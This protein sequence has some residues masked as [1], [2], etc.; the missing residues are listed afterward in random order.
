MPPPSC[1]PPP[2]GLQGDHRG[3]DRRPWPLGSGATSDVPRTELPGPSPRTDARTRRPSMSPEPR[4]AQ[5]GRR[6][7]GG[8]AAPPPRD[9]PEQPYL[10]LFSSPASQAPQDPQEGGPSAA[11]PPPP[12][13][14]PR[15]PLGLPAPRS[16]GRGARQ[17]RGPG[18]PRARG[19]PFSPEASPTQAWRA[20]SAL[21]RP[22]PLQGAPPA[23]QSPGLPVG[24]SSR[25]LDHPR[26]LATQPGR[27]LWLQ[28]GSRAGTTVS[29]C[30][31]SPGAMPGHVC[32][33]AGQ[34]WGLGWAGTAEPN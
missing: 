26:P 13:C 2:W 33:S 32:R 12:W 10:V 20:C 16:S 28:L 21:H 11:C 23:A 29:C 27:P 24:G 15:P 4:S 19:S 5:E 25:Q 31:G 6:A 1:E 22:A 3:G 9:P 17:P 8:R 30:S 14:A 18:A 34:A 7:G